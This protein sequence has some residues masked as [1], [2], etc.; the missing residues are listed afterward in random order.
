MLMESI[1]LEKRSKKK[2]LGQV[3]ISED[4]DEILI[5][6]NVH[7]SIYNIIYA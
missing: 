6:D 4:C 1:E 3:N 5:R 2:T 7:K